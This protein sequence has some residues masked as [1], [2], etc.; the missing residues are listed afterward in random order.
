M[1]D[2]PRKDPAMARKLRIGAVS[3]LNSKPLIEGLSTLAP[4]A[5]LIL[6]VPSRLA[7]ALQRGQLDVALIP[8]VEAFGDPDYEV[9]SDAC[10]ATRG[11]V[12]SVKLYSRV[13]PGDIRSLALDEGSRTSSAL[14][15]VMLEER[16]GVRPRLQP[17]PLGKSVA[18]TSAD[19]ILLI[20]D[21]A[22]HPPA[23]E[24]HTVWDLGQEWL[25]WT[26][27]PFVFAMWVAR[28]ETPLHGLD[29]ALEQTRD[30]G[31]ANIPSIARREAPKLQLAPETAESY[32]RKNL[33]FQ[34][35]SAERH[36][37]ELFHELAASQ[38]FAP[39]GQLAFRE[40]GSECTRDLV[41]SLA[42]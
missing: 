19:A 33:H 39:A 36:A 41:G 20:G 25:Q 15:Q 26:G 2:R 3:Y 38:G 22:M 31:V 21:R 8:S 34:I 9:V 42:Q 27:L 40:S 5:E 14:V 13:F 18:D 30:L 12:L 37:L 35:G 4:D 23:E 24:F 10:V 11:P 1:I 6:D 16:F 29:V 28:K 17:L 7:D 32:L